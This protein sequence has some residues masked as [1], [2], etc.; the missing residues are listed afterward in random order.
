MHMA[1]GE[2]LV[3][4]GD[5][6]GNVSRYQTQELSSGSYAPVSATPADSMNMKDKLPS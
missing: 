2:G 4:E 1:G 3:N 6:N 5:T